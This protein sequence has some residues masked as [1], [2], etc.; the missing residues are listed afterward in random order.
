ML[1]I[2]KNGVG[3]TYAELESVFGECITVEKRP[4]GVIITVNDG[5]ISGCS[6]HLDDEKLGQLINAI[7]IIR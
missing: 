7:N 1:K 4:N 3:E 5:D 6:V 2:L